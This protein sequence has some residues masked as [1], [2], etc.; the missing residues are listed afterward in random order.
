MK[1]KLVSLYDP[2]HQGELADRCMVNISLICQAV[3]EFGPK[4]ATE[5]AVCR[6]ALELRDEYAKRAK[7]R[8]R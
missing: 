1:R 8:W 4:K 7:K 2:I 6:R 3:Q 5:D